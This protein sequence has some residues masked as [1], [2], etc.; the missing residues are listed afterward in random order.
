ML[1]FKWSYCGH[2]K[3]MMVICPICGNNC[4][5]GGSGEID[6]KKCEICYLAYQY[7]ALAWK[8]NDHPE[9]SEEEK[10]KEEDRHEALLSGLFGPDELIKEKP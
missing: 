9:W 1:E 7:Q 6:G 5:N 10:R 3:T 2:C 4:C 8:H